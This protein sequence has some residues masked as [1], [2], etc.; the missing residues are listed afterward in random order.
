MEFEQEPDALCSEHANKWM[1]N[2]IFAKM[3]HVYG[4]SLRHHSYMIQQGCPN[5]LSPFFR[6]LQPG[7]WQKRNAPNCWY[8]NRLLEQSPIP[9]KL[10]YRKP[11]N[12]WMRLF[13]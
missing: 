7:S 3:V 2:V 1:R 4:Y 6:I 9:M 5:I 13:R 8:A 12:A 10:L 11:T